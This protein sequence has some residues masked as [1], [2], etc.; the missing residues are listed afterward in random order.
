MLQIVLILTLLL[1]PAATRADDASLLGPAANASSSQNQSAVNGAT[2]QPTTANGGS[3]LQSANSGGAAQAGD[4]QTLQQAGD[5]AA[6]KLFVQ[7]ETESST[8][9]EPQPTHWLEYAL[10]IGVAIG[11]GG[12]A[13]WL[14]RR[15]PKQR[16][17]ETTPH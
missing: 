5:A 17:A 8:A 10:I 6:M 16:S 2:L 1:W 9:P 14:S 13:W 7:V 4:A 3:E 15:R 12:A 11:A